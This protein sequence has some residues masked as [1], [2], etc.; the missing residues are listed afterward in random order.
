MCIQ[1]LLFQ[2]DVGSRPLFILGQ[3]WD[4]CHLNK[5]E[6][7]LGRGISLLWLHRPGSQSRFCDL[8][9]APVSCGHCN[10]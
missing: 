2:E 9:G 10:R 8:L 3:E 5:E 1:C 7:D 6:T 4:Y